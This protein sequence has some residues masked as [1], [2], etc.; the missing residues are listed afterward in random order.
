[1]QVWWLF[2]LASITLMNEH[3]CNG[4]KVS[5]QN[6]IEPQPTGQCPLSTPSLVV[7]GA[8]LSFNSSMNRPENIS[9]FK[10]FSNSQTHVDFWKMQILFFFYFFFI[11]VFVAKIFFSDMSL[12]FMLKRNSHKSKTNFATNTS[13]KKKQSILWFYSNLH[14][15]WFSDKIY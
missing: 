1:M 6:V 13:K 9:F 12:F 7:K 2:P 15:S 4:C 11:D 8:L 3:V 10:F 5:L 14:L